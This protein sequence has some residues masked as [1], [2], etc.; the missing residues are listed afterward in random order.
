MQF[1]QI[2]HNLAAAMPGA[3]EH[4][5]E[6]GKEEDTEAHLKRDRNGETPVGNNSL[7]SEYFIY[8]FC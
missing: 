3:T 4:G 7:P 1:K 6:C 8:L 5:W 2:M